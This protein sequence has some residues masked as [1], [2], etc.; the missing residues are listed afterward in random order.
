MAQSGREETEVIIK[1]YGRIRIRNF[2]HPSSGRPMAGTKYFIEKPFNDNLLGVVIPM[3]NEPADALRRTLL[4]IH[5][6]MI[7]F[8]Y[9]DQQRFVP[10]I[11]LILDGWTPKDGMGVFFSI[12]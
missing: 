6:Q 9:K 1:Q 8:E 5:D 11:L 12:M 2:G 4:S 10:H 3:Y 7:H